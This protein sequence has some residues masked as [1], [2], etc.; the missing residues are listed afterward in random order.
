MIKINM[1]FFVAGGV[2]LILTGALQLAVRPRKPN[3][4]RWLNRGTLWGGFCIAVGLGIA[5]AAAGILP[6]WRP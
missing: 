2:I 6:I 1:G 3:E 5:L 4:H